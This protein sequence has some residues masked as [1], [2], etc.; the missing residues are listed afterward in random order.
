VISEYALYAVYAIVALLVVIIVY[1]HRIEES[2]EGVGQGV[3]KLHAA[4]SGLEYHLKHRNP[5]H[6]DE[7]P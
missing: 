1:L 2:I 4:V 3:G 5:Q 6:W 7:E